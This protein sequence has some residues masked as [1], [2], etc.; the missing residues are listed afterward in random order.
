[1]LFEQDD[2]IAL[3][4]VEHTAS[5][6]NGAI[7]GAAQ[8]LDQADAGQRGL[9]QRR[10]VRRAVKDDQSVGRAELA[11][12]SRKQ[13]RHIDGAAGSRDENVDAKRADGAEFLSI[14]D[15]GRIW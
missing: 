5:Q 9:V 15:R 10:A 2:D 14:G 1:M 8:M 6:M 11:A 3:G 12:Q 7:A 13:R 4:D